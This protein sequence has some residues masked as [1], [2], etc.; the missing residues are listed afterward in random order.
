MTNKPTT[1]AARAFLP[2]GQVKGQT[3]MTPK[4]AKVWAGELEA[5]AFELARKAGEVTIRRCYARTE[6]GTYNRVPPRTMRE[7]IEAI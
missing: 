6:T 1:Y 7:V 5:P 3:G 2:G 4:I